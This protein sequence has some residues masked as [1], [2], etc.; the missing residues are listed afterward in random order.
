MKKLL[1]LLIVVFAL[2]LTGCMSYL[3]NIRDDAT[4]F[5]NIGVTK[6]FGV[7]VAWGPLAVGLGASGNEGFGLFP[8]ST[9]PQNGVGIVGIYPL[10]GGIHYAAEEDH[11]LIEAKS[12]Y[13]MFNHSDVT[14]Y[15][16]EASLI[17]F[18]TNSKYWL[19]PP[20]KRLA[21]I[22]LFVGAYYGLYVSFDPV[23]LVDL[24]INTVNID[25]CGD[26]IH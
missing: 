8:R 22:Q 1:L 6:S 14:E 24:I 18:H 26:S 21:E 4:D 20:G 17:F 9:E 13:F 19:A 5:L 15:S 11:A 16:D 10:Y 7:G 25:I 3:K 12:D 2:T 23:E